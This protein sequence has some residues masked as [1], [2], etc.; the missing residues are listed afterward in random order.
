MTPTRNHPLHRALAL[1]PCVALLCTALACFGDT[2]RDGAAVSPVEP[3]PARQASLGIAPTAATLF[4]GGSQQFQASFQDATGRLVDD[5]DVQWASADTSIAIV[6][7]QGRATAMAPGV[8]SIVAKL[9]ETVAAAQLVVLDSAAL[10]T[11]K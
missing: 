9:G 5:P 1:T 6:D 3:Y 10:R 2:K 11:R 4:L 8:T 7:S